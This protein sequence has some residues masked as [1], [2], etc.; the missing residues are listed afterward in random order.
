VDPSAILASLFNP[1]N[2]SHS[3]VDY[4]SVSDTEEDNYCQDDNSTSDS[5]ARPDSAVATEASPPVDS[6]FP[7][8][9]TRNGTQQSLD[10]WRTYMIDWLS[11]DPNFEPF[12]N[13]LTWS[14]LT[15]SQPF[16]GLSTDPPPG[17]HASMKLLALNA[18]LARISM[19]CPVIT[20]SLISTR[21]TSVYG[22]WQLVYN[23]F[24][25]TLQ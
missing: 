11:D 15:S 4:H 18:L 7:R 12:L 23:H 19:L 8:T 25:C 3:N 20:S 9:L 16:R 24:N 5:E 10:R 1:N 2:D 6:T 14:R 17:K 13:G 21:S 22:I